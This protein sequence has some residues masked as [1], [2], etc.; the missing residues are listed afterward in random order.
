MFRLSISMRW[1]ARCTACVRN[2]VRN[3]NDI[4]THI[5]IYIENRIVIVILCSIA[6][7]AREFRCSS[8]SFIR[9]I[10][11]FRIFFFFRS[12]LAYSFAKNSASWC[13]NRLYSTPR[14][15]WWIRKGIKGW[16]CGVPIMYFESNG[17][18]LNFS[19]WFSSI[20]HRFRR[21]SLYG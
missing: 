8:N 16:I 9:W 10:V 17:F 20:F 6:F 12:I 7:H 14:W 18:V 1:L 19:R 2:A 5:Y 15:R 11:W 13:R 21:F 4:S 3:E